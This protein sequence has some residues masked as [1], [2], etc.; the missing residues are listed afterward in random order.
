[1][2]ASETGNAARVARDF[3]DACTLSH[4]ADAMDDVDME[5]IDGKTVVFFVATCGQGAMP[6]NGQNF[7]KELSQR[8]EPFKE[9]TR[10]MVMGL[11]DSSYYFFCKAAHDVEEKMLALG[12]K[13]ML[14]V[15]YG[16]DSAEEGMEEGL[17][18]WLAKVWPALEVP[19]PAEVPHITPVK[20]SFSQKA[21]NNPDIDR[22]SLEQYFYSDAVQAVSLPVLSNKKMCREDYDRDFRTI[23]IS[24]VGN[25]K[26]LSYELGDALEIFPR[27][28][29][30]K[31]S[32][33]LHAYSHDF[34][35]R[36]VV[37]L[38]AY[39]IDG[40]I[41][42][43]ALFTNVLDLFGKPSA[44]FMQQLATFETDEEEKKIMLDLGFL[45]KAGKETG[46]TVADALLRFKKAHPPLPALLAIIPPIKPRA[47][48]IASA[49]A[50]SG[51]VIELLV[52]IDTWWCDEGMRYGLNCDMLRQTV[53]GDHLWC[54]MKAGSMEP[55]EPEQPVVCAGIGSGLAPH[56]AFLRDHVRAAEAGE[57]VGD[58]SLYF[59]NRK[60]LDEYCYREEL[61]GYEKKYSWF[62]LHAAFSRDAPKPKVYVQD[63]V[64]KTDDAR[65]L[66]R[67]QPGML[68]ICGNRNLPKPMQDALVAS[69][70]QHSD[71]PEV[72][73]KAKA[74]VEDM[75]VHGRAQQEV[76]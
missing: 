57:K 50:V 59:G 54:R 11:G 41:S 13:K 17:H 56:M 19:P 12:A 3:A 34:D 36:T 75:Y 28:D 61:E 74:D 35:E 68:Y 48:S 55:P 1:L 22:H 38:H 71:D 47:Y 8:T 7:F 40:E 45:K 24:C 70:T 9:G 5:D 42:L 18:D 4:N 2:Y 51:N 66:L 62:K 15:G 63:L 65:L 52:L 16:D 26:T 76:W 64:A 49:P 23:R 29:P 30:N 58:F 67:D 27:N 46:L 72:I 21:I 20:V 43:G 25:N 69:F 60:E 39:G 73:K 10:F 14:D 44:H 37:N 33:F 32:D 31:V 53:A 6:K